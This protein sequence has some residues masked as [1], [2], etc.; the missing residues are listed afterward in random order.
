MALVKFADSIR[1]ASSG[2]LAT[3]VCEGDACT[4]SHEGQHLFST[5]NKQGTDEMNIREKMKAANIKLEDINAAAAS[6]SLQDLKALTVALSAA[7]KEKEAQTGKKAQRLAKLSAAMAATDDMTQR[8]VTVVRG[9]LRRLG[10]A[11][12]AINARAHEGFDVAEMDAKMR[13]AK[14]D[15]LRCMQMKSRMDQLGLLNY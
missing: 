3:C 14:W 9:E 7:A 5:S 6:M 12:D 8:Q 13:E 1:S 11:G 15:T 2:F 4:C 10:F